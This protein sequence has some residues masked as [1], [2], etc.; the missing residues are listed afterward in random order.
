M[1]PKFDLKGIRTHD[2]WILNR[3]FRPRD[4]LDHSA[5]MDL[6]IYKQVFLAVQA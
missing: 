4:A 5:I 3:I 2:L 1:Y 6:H